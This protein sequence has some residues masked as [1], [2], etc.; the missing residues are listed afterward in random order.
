MEQRKIKGDLTQKIF[1]LYSQEAYRNELKKKLGPI[2]LFTL[3]RKMILNSKDTD[4]VVD[5]KENAEGGINIRIES[6]EWYGK[7]TLLGQVHV[8]SLYIFL[9]IMSKSKYN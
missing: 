7:E 2:F 5:N 1:C 6:L 9:I 4:P 3:G 8:L